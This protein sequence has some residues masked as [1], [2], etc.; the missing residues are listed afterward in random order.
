MDPDEV[1]FFENLGLTYTETIAKGGYGLVYLVHSDHY[2]SY[3]AMKK[4]PEK[5]FNEAEVNCLKAIY[6]PN[7]V[8]LY[9]YYKFQNYVY[10]LMNIALQIL[11]E[12]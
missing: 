8:A 1:V 12:S 3:F 6:D 9:N 11:R 2:Q 5:L 7:I 4:I 10:M